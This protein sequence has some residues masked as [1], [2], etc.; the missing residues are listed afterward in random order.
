MSSKAKREMEAAGQEQIPILA[1]VDEW[2]QKEDKSSEKKN[3]SCLN[4]VGSALQARRPGKNPSSCLLYYSRPKKVS[5][6]L[7][8]S[9]KLKSNQKRDEMKKVVVEG[10]DLTF[11]ESRQSQIIIIIFQSSV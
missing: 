5:N 8:G 3:A 11:I 7:T 9:V 10:L 1:I 6:A 2:L 4:K